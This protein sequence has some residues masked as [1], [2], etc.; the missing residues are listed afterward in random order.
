MVRTTSNPKTQ[1]STSH[2]QNYRV[3]KTRR[4]TPGVRVVVEGPTMT[5]A[6]QS[7]ILELL[8]SAQRHRPLL[9]A[10]RRSVPQQANIQSKPV[11]ASLFTE[12]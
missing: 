10:S 4:W 6:Q 1:Y 9:I 5:M 8:G 11:H 3:G 12:P 2:I 7:V